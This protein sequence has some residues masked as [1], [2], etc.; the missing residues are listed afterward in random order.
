MIARTNHRANGF[1]LIEL[2]VSMALGLMLVAML[3]TIFA[4]TSGARAELQRSSQMVDNGRYAVD[5][6]TEDLQI[7]GFFGELNVGA[8]ALPAALPD[9][10]STAPVDWAAAMP[11]HVQGYDEGANPP[12]CMPNSVVANTDILAVRRGRTCVAGTAGCEAIV[13]SQLYLQVGLCDALT[14]SFVVGIAGDIA[15]PLLTKDCVTIAGRRRYV[16]HIY[17]VSTDNGS[18]VSIPTLKRLEFNGAGYTEVALVEG[19][20]RLQIE[21]GMDTDGDGSPDTYTADPT[22][23]APAGCAVCSAPANWSNVVTVK[24]HVLSR[25]TE[26]S[27][28]YVNNKVYELGLN[29]ARAPIRVGPFNDAY[30]RHVYSAAVRIMNP[31]GRRDTP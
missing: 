15:W 16:G 25:A 19:I 5:L 10:C 9:L 17:F 4:N 3:G 31:S 8:L 26:I 30:R 14:N 11:V 7:A 1:S 20:E 18:G 24:L 12:T 6:L 2:M 13:A 21:Y 29:A 27:P 28:G 23:Y 22:T